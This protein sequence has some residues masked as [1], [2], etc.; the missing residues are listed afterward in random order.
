MDLNISSD[1]VADPVPVPVTDPLVSGGDD[2]KGKKKGKIPLPD[3]TNPESR[4][5]YA[6]QFTQ[7]YGPLMS[8]R[9]DTPLRINEVPATW[10]DKLTSKELSTNA[11]TKLGLDPALL[12]SSAM[13]EGMSGL[14][15]GKDEK[16]KDKEVDFSGDEN[17]PVSGY[18]NFGLD[19]FSDAFPGLV[20]KG[21]LPKDFDKQFKKSVEAPRQGDNKTAV[22][23]ANFSSADA[24]LQAKA[25]MIKASK[26]EVESFSKNNKIPLSDKAKDFFTLINY[27][28]GSGNA[29]KMLKEYNRIG[30]LKD[31]S[32]LNKRPSESWKVPY[33][34]VIRRIK[35]ADALKEE[36]Y[37]DE[38]NGEK[39]N[40]P[41]ANVAANVSQ[42]QKFDMFDQKSFIQ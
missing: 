34:N 22:N 28:A 16:G 13:E 14:Y 21:Y 26:D 37:F 4:L 12:Y 5:G 23:S 41:K 24:A 6:K 31:D 18:V 19:N 7:K 3:Y 30:A 42:P 8:G 10:K 40:T 11:A 2:P 20:K 39:V 29:Q 1:N 36:G 32:F 25:A 33:E 15:P 27:N 35:M 17:F 38:Q 9:G